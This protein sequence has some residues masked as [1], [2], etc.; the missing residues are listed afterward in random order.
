MN[1]DWSLLVVAALATMGLTPVAGV[2]MRR[3]QVV[4]RPQSSLRKI[5]RRP[6]PLG[7]GWA[8]FLVFFGGLALLWQYDSHINDFLAVPAALAFFGGGLVLMLGGFWDDKYSLRPRQQIIFPLLAAVIAVLGGIGPLA[9]T[10]PLG[11]TIDLSR[12]QF[13]ILEVTL[14]AANVVTFMWLMGLMF[15]TK[16][17]DGLD[18]LVAGVVGIGAI[19]LYFLTQQ[20][21]WYQPELGRII[22]VFA[23]ACLGFLV[24]NFHPA[25]IFL[26]EGGS[27]LMGYLLAVLAVL[28]GGKIMTAFLV[29]GLPALD[30]LRV[31]VRRWQKRKPIFVGDREHLH[32]QLLAAGLSQRQAVLLLYAIAVI[33]GVSGLVLQNVHKI[34][35]L[36]ALLV[37]M[38]LVS[39]WIIRQ[40]R[41][42]R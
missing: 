39:A 8:V 13:S 22:M 37:V 30:V 19:I 40:E 14:T 28:A 4:D 10:N 11:G 41:Q 33:F 1:L 34:I 20:P 17:L 16:F 36:V 7:G 5:H 25:K 6:T 38:G 3:W 24:W 12:W 2:L 31:I 15:T 29:L 26:G 27:L 9:L 18:G 32:F 35:A 21:A 23:G 42:S